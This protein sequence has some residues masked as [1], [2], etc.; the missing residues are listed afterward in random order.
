[1]KIEELQIPA[2]W[3]HI[4]VFSSCF[5]V[6][7]KIW[8]D[9]ENEIIV[10]VHG[11]LD[12][13][14]SFDNLIPLLSE[15]FCYVCLDLPGHGLSSHIHESIPIHTVDYT[16]S[17]RV[18]LDYLKRQ[19][20]IL[21][22]HS[23]GG[24]ICIFFTMLYPNRIS[25]LI[26]LDSLAFQPIYPNF[27]VKKLFSH[28][29]IILG[30]K[31]NKSKIKSYT[32]EE[33][34]DKIVESRSHGCFNRKGAE[35]L[36]KRMI[37]ETTDVKAWG[38]QSNEAVILSHGFLD[39]AATFDRL[40][41]L[42]PNNFYYLSI[43]LP[44]H[45][46]S[47]GFHDSMPVHYV[48]YLLCYKLVTRHFQRSRYILLGHSFGGTL[49]V[50]F[51]Q[52]YP[53]I[54]S[55]LVILDVIYQMPVDPLMFASMMKNAHNIYF[56]NLERNFDGRQGYTY[57]E[58]VNKVRESRYTGWLTI[59]AADILASRMVK[60]LDNGKYVLTLDPKL[61]GLILP[62]ATPDY[63]IELNNLY[64]VKCPV[65]MLLTPDNDFNH[66]S[67]YLLERFREANFCVK[68]IDDHHHVHLT[69]PEVIADHISNFLINIQIKLWGN[70]K[71]E[72]MLVIHGVLDNAGAFDNL[73]PHLPANVYYICIDLPSHGRSSNFPLTLPIHTIN[74]VVPIRIVAEYFKREK[75]IVMG[76]S[77]GGQVLMFYA[78]L[79]PESISK[80]ILLDAMY[81]FPFD[82]NIFLDITRS[83]IDR[84]FRLFKDG[85]SARPTFT[86]EEAIQK[87]IAGRD[88]DNMTRFA[89]EPLVKR[90]FVK[91]GE[92]K[93]VMNIDSR[94]K[95]RFYPSGTIKFIVKL[96]QRDP[97]E[98]PVLVLLST[99]R[100]LADIFLPLYNY[101]VEKGYEIHKYAGHHDMHNTDPEVIAPYVVRFL[102]KDKNKL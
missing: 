67:Q 2:P 55:K 41:P 93:Y 14:G 64:P 75:Y 38:V 68:T 82:E 8:G 92:D 40:I 44:G 96:Q 87:L 30:T 12:N 43:D 61:R 98:C 73:I 53:E 22:G 62:S 34:V 25:K 1:M 16:L 18:V 79:Y 69:N 90:M 23:L 80:V 84:L 83:G 89:A 51:A 5:F 46:L 97:V 78:Q 85:E 71:N 66:K 4:A 29:D 91:V 99:Q 21:L 52:L 39:N 15:K 54:V 42:L 59:E 50:L 60:K 48:N 65:L 13:A 6:A 100:N 32:Y 49:T 17:L 86:Y 24:Q 10:L 76:H 88:H 63:Y 31:A 101:Y 11:L 20:Y 7:V 57:E 72:A 95:E 56:K 9:Q 81:L 35:P 33:C 28:H 102:M 26:T 77:L 70:P 3:G 47:T 74:F 94:L 27:Y 45:G 58:I 19:K 36:V 37:K